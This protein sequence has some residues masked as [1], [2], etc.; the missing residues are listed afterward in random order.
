MNHCSRIVLIVMFLAVC[1]QAMSQDCRAIVMP[2]Y[3][4]NEDAFNRVPEGKVEVFCNYS[5][6]M[7]YE[8]DSLPKDAYVYSISELVSRLDGQHI[9]KGFVV[10]LNTLSYYEYN[11]SDFQVKHF[12]SHIYFSTPASAH[13]YLGVRTMEEALKMS[14]PDK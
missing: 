1:G 9:D 11:F 6:A 12:Y 5:Q 7:F 3:G 8:T 10:D 2:K 14:S 13:K 4:N